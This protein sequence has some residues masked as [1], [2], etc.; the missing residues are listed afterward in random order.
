VTGGTSPEDGAFARAVAEVVRRLP[1]GTVATYGEVA[2]EAGRPGAARAVGRALRQ[3]DDLPWWRVVPASGRLA[4]TVAERQAELLRGEGV[5]V[6][7]GRL[8][9]PQGLAR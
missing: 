1:P 5:P 8:P 7:G 3:A 4:P 6:D 2:A 9:P